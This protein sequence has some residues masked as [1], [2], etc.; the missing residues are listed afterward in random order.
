MANDI[1]SSSAHPEVPELTELSPL[2]PT[3]VK[4]WPGPEPWSAGPTEVMVVRAG[5]RLLYDSNGNFRFEYIADV[6]VNRAYRYYY[7]ADALDAGGRRLDV[8]VYEPFHDAHPGVNYNN[9]PGHSID[10]QKH[11]AAIADWIRVGKGRWT[12]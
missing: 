4:E 6:L 8:Y 2:P 12:T 5:M 11:Y 1:T 7:A 3:R 9:Y 10:I